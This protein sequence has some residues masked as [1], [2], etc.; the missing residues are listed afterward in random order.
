MEECDLDDSRRL[1][2]RREKTRRSKW[3]RRRLFE[4]ASNCDDTRRIKLRRSH[5][6]RTCPPKQQK[7]QVA[8]RR[9]DYC[10]EHDIHH[11]YKYMKHCISL[12]PIYRTLYTCTITSFG[13]SASALSL[14]V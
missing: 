3:A 11:T 10:C 9:R 13:A 6:G 1:E 2:G 7:L 14:T 8:R 4:K 5:S 12:H